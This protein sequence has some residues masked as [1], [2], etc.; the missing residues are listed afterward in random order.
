MV[1]GRNNKPE[2]HYIKIH[3]KKWQNDIN[4]KEYLEWLDNQGGDTPINKIMLQEDLE[5]LNEINKYFNS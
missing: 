3:K 5:A 4:Y 2:N 1:F